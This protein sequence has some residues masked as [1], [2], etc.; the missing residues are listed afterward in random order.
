[1]KV[2][3]ETTTGNRLVDRL[4]HMIASVLS[5]ETEHT[6]NTIDNCK[7]DILFGDSYDSLESLVD[8]FTSDCQAELAKDPDNYVTNAEGETRRLHW[9]HLSAGCGARST[10]LE[11]QRVIV[12]L[13][14]NALR[15]QHHYNNNNNNN[16]YYDDDD[17]YYSYY[18][19]Y[20]Y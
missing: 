13:V 20:Y 9:R 8:S 17:Y 16:Y 19:Y 3:W 12:L 18:Y 10:T 1:M 15:D 4:L 2:L 11:N 14:Y 5:E 6:G 7:E